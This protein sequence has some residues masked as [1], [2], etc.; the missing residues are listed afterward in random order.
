M[1]PLLLGFMIFGAAAGK[2]RIALGRASMLD[3]HDRRVRGFVLLSFFPANFNYIPFAIV[4]PD[5]RSVRRIRGAQHAAIMN[6]LPRDARGLG[7]DARDIS[8][9]R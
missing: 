9:C 5:R 3:R 7:Q 6:A 1:I 4:C 2:L 8:E